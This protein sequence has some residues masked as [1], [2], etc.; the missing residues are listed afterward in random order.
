MIRR[1]ATAERRYTAG[2]SLPAR[3]GLYASGTQ[4]NTASP[5]KRG[6]TILV[7]PE[8]G[9]RAR[10]D[11]RGFGVGT[12]ATRGVA[13]ER[14]DPA[15][16]REGR[17]EREPAPPV[18]PATLGSSRDDAAV[19]GGYV[20]TPPRSFSRWWVTLSYSLS[21]LS[22]PRRSKCLTA[23]GAARR[24]LSNGEYQREDGNSWAH[25]RGTELGT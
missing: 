1:G 22:T 6:A 8:R 5:R 17:W 4:V 21:H 24:P 3:S 20:L 2:F 18:S 10:R 14:T 13:V 11:S 12:R 16:G 9:S 7:S 25:Q 19:V 15:G 23:D